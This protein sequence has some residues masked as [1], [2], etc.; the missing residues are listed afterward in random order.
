[1][2]NTQI[3]KRKATKGLN[4]CLCASKFY[5]RAVMM[6]LKHN[7]SQLIIEKNLKGVGS[8]QPDFSS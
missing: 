1:M 6:N 7:I 3:L 4:Q 2:K 5:T 8:K